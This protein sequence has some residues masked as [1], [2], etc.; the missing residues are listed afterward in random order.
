MHTSFYTPHA[1]ST[2]FLLRVRRALQGAELLLARIFA[3]RNDF[4]AAESV[5]PE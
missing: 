2:R 1:P 3:R 4:A 5:R